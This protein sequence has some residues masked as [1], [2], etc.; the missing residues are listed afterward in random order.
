MRERQRF[1]ADAMLGSLA[2]WLRTLGCDVEYERHIS[3]G[4][5]IQRA[6]SEG[7]IVL[8]RDTLL[9]KRRALSG[10]CFFVKGDHIEGQLR[11]VV[12]NFDLKGAVVLTRCLRCG[13]VLADVEK[14]SVKGLVPEYVLMTQERFS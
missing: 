2:R 13:R 8:T 7:R 14:A 9:A 12:E 10:R 1:F 6:L 4:A 11:Q 3:D 5:L